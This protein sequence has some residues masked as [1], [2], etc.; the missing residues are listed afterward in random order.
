MG[1][2]GNGGVIMGWLENEEEDLKWWGVIFS[3]LYGWCSDGKARKGSIY[4]LF[5][6]ILLLL[7]LFTLCL[8]FQ[9]CIR[10]WEVSTQV[11]WIICKSCILWLIYALTCCAW[12][13]EREQSM[14]P[15]FRNK[16]A[17]FWFVYTRMKAK[18]R[19]LQSVTHQKLA[20]SDLLSPM[21]CSYRE[22][23]FIFWIFEITEV[24]HSY[25]GMNK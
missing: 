12:E 2:G 6:C 7:V 15:Q 24:H 25:T 9:F 20:S 19:V 14:I 23:L 13:R 5:I 10:K 3:L 4:Y 21:R 22:I 16:F 18:V 17:Q 1:R 11:V 8:Q